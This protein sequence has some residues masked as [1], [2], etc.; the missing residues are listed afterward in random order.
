MNI[1]KYFRILCPI[2][3]ILTCETLHGTNPKDNPYD[4]NRT[5]DIPS[6][7]N[8]RGKYRV[9]CYPSIYEKDGNEKE[10]IVPK[11]GT[12][13]PEYPYE[14][15][16]RRISGEVSV[17]YS[18][19]N[20]KVYNAWIWKQSNPL[21]GAAALSAVRTWS[22]DGEAKDM[23]ETGATFYFCI[24]DDIPK[25]SGF[26]SIG[27]FMQNNIAPASGR[28]CYPTFQPL[29]DYPEEWVTKRTSGFA[30]IKILV[31]PNNKVVDVEIKDASTEA[32]GA[33]AVEYCKKWQFA[34]E[35]SVK[36]EKTDELFFRID[37]LTDIVGLNDGE[38]MS[39]T[40]R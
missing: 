31:S 33:L 32:I 36:K 16:L 15:R 2:W 21:F 25:K 18:I 9:Y 14:M 20:G 13:I 23:S 27:V 17:I 34:R 8:T 38:G 10:W 37:L 22:F 39:R 1:V 11:E 29:F 6:P 35:L 3:M 7:A 5:P 30:L 4:I 40:D 28:Y 19:G 24:D 26:F 12:L